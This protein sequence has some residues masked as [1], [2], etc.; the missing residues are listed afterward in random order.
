MVVSISRVAGE[1]REGA[2]DLRPRARLLVARA[3]G[4]SRRTNRTGARLLIALRTEIR[5]AVIGG[6]FCVLVDIV[7]EGRVCKEVVGS[8]VDDLEYLYV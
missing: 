4:L 1:G 5:A 6:G 7:R 3:T 8:F 2:E